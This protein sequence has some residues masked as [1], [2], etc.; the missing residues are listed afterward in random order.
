M[1]N[2][3]SS[4]VSFGSSVFAFVLWSLAAYMVT[5][6]LGY[7]SP[8]K[9]AP[10]L[11]GGITLLLLTVIVGRE[12]TIHIR[13]RT[14]RAHAVT[15]AE[16]PADGHGESAADVGQGEPVNDA[17]QLAVAAERA[18]SVAVPVSRRDEAAAL[19]W[20]SAS[21]VAMILFGFLIGMSVAMVTLMKVYARERW[22]ISLIVT[23]SVLVT[24]YVFFGRILNVA[25]Y[26]GLLDLG[27]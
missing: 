5:Q 22:P 20:G 2:E 13:H 12:V 8:P 19:V 10:L 11:F 25:F 3:P 15:T 23:G 21:I 7:S 6:A 9:L 27:F 17:E 26:P 16:S 18:G 14:S 1:A 4:Q 24:L